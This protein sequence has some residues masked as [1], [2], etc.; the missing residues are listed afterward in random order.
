MAEYH[1][2]SPLTEEDVRKLKIGDIVYISGTMVTARDSAHKRALTLAKEGR[3]DEIPVNFE[4]L[5]LYHCGPVVK[6]LDGEWKF[7]AGGPTTSAR[8]ESIEGDFIRTFKVRAII[9]KGGMG[10]N[11][12]GAAKEVGAF[13]GAFTGGAAALAAKSI[14]R[15]VDV[16]WLDLGTPEAVWVLEVENFGP[17]IVAIDSYGNN[18]YEQVMKEVDENKRKVLESLNLL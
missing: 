5:A 4:G 16:H 18:L 6:K 15:I 7:I 11:T 1:L 2:K 3:F 14:K 9:G 17:L 8:M 13:Y 10:K 12:A